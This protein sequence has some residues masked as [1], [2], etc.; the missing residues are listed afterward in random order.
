MMMAVDF[1]AADAAPTTKQQ[2]LAYQGAVRSAPWQRCAY[3]AAKTNLRKFGIQR[4]VRSA[5]LA[6]NLDIKTYDVGN[7]FVATQGTTVTGS[8]AELYV[9]YDVELFT[10]QLTAAESVVPP[11][12]YAWMDYV[13]DASVANFGNLWGVGGTPVVQTQ[14]N[15]GA[16]VLPGP[17]GAIGFPNVPEDRYFL[18]SYF[19]DGTTLNPPS[20]T[21]TAGVSFD[22]T[23]GRSLD[24]T[25]SLASGILAV[26][27][28]AGRAIGAVQ[29]GSTYVGGSFSIA[30]LQ[31]LIPMSKDC[32]E[33]SDDELQTYQVLKRRFEKLNIKEDAAELAAVCF[34]QKRRL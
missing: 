16:F 26:T 30:Y 31:G 34:P 13:S 24:G 29:T 27:S 19:C 15:L 32:S 25:E 14:G 8:L 11:I 7:L 2:L 6:S 5:A 20:F 4:Y 9:D 22:I 23:E 1:D 3:I 28:G 10:P 21:A 17:A 33:T 18:F 12:P